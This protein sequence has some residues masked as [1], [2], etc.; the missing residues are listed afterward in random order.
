MKNLFK[1]LTEKLPMPLILIFTLVIIFNLKYGCPIQFFT[2][3]SCLGCGMSRAALA[4]LKPDFELALRMHPLIYFMP[5]CVVVLLLKKHIPPRFT[6]VFFGI[7]IALF[8]TVYIYRIITG[9]DVVL[10]NPEEG[11]IYRL[12]TSIFNI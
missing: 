11:Y 12:I 9:S 5:V 2:G 8:I 6:K 1:K 7:T 3:I 4:L 10:I